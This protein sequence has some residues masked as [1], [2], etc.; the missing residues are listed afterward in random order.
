VCSSDLTSTNPTSSSWTVV[1]DTADMDGV[2]WSW[3]LGYTVDL[4]AWSGTAIRVAFHYYGTTGDDKWYIDDLCVGVDAD[5]DGDPDS[6]F[7]QE[8]FEV[9]GYPNLPM[10]WVT[11]DGPANDS[12]TDWRTSLDNYHTGLTSAL[13]E[14]PDPGETSDSYLIS[15]AISLP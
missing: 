14:N 6:C 10:G 9:P 13:R 15:P 11:H 5:T 8:G 4:S 2:G 12:A 7:Y 1:A 3:G